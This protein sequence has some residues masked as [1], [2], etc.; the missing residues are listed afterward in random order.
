MLVNIINELKKIYFEGG[1]TNLTNR[2]LI[3]CK[4]YNDVVTLLQ[5]EKNNYDIME[6]CSI[7]IDKHDDYIEY[8]SIC[9][10]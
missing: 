6:Y 4:I 5:L 2:N 9:N 7:I 8:I 3:K 10:D 1:I